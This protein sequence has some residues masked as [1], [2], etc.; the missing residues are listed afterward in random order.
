[1]TESNVKQG[2][3]GGLPCSFLEIE[4]KCPNLAKQCP[5]FG[6][7]CPV[8]MHLWIDLLLNI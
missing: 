6:R 3:G 8:C 2:E 4:G 7:K 5:N 1:M